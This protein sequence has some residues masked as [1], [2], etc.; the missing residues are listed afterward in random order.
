MSNINL[1]I[2][3]LFIN[4]TFLYI[5]TLNGIAKSMS[6][7]LNLTNNNDNNSSI[8]RGHWLFIVCGL[9]TILRGYFSGNNNNNN[10]NNNTDISKLY[11]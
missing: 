1:N 9:T 4:L 5:L 2:L 3:F 10:N 7:L 11:C 6:D 8:P